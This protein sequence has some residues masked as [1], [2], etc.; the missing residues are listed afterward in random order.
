VIVVKGYHTKWQVPE[1]HRA[2]AEYIEAGARITLGQAV[3]DRRTALGKRISALA[4]T[5]LPALPGR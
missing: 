1:E 2:S 3:Y 4:A 5:N